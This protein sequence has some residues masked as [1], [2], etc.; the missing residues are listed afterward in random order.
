MLY[1]TDL[2]ATYIPFESAGEGVVYIQRKLL[3]QL[4]E[5]EEK[6]EVGIFVEMTNFPDRGNETF[7]EW[8]K[9]Q[10]EFYHTEIGSLLSAL[11]KIREKKFSF[12]VSPF[13]YIK[14]NWSSLKYIC[15]ET[16]IIHDVYVQE[17]PEVNFVWHSESYSPGGS[18]QDDA[19]QSVPL[20]DLKLNQKYEMPNK[21]ANTA[22][23]IIDSDFNF[24]HLDHAESE[25]IYPTYYD[26][27]SE[28]DLSD[29]K[30]DVGTE[31]QCK[32]EYRHG[33]IMTKIICGVASEKTSI[34]I[35]T[36]P[37]AMN[38]EQ[39]ILHAINYIL[40]K[41]RELNKKLNIVL[42][43]LGSEKFMYKFLF[44]IFWSKF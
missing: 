17:N 44:I 10:Q 6:V 25:K 36:V 4:L 24:S 33:T 22:V 37:K 15:T 26:Y 32:G 29:I 43:T 11:E 8:K 39:H 5:C 38:K 2:K 21:T 35:V 34:H 41:S 12:I 27:S 18:I 9:K 42:I 1:F 16:N 19:T 7:E 23:W 31:E 13:W 14:I 20:A 28:E 30:H 40:Q 3:M